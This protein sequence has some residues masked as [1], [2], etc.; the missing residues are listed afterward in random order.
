MSALGALVAE[1]WVRVVFGTL[2]AVGQAAGGAR[3]AGRLDHRPRVPA[4]AVSIDDQRSRALSRPAARVGAAAR[5]H[6]ARD[7]LDDSATCSRPSHA[8]GT[9]RA[10]RRPRRGA[11]RRHRRAAP[12]RRIALSAACAAGAW[13][14]P[15]AVAV[16]VDPAGKRTPTTRAASSGSTR[17]S[18]I[19][20]RKDEHVRCEAVAALVR[21][22]PQSRASSSR[23]ASAP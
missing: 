8:C 14:G 6:S 18:W 13:T 17:P 10:R 12:P 20:R 2:V 9:G 3:R 1:S 23:P 5:G 19:A 16:E 7:L 22:E 11:G 21:G 4:R 15:S